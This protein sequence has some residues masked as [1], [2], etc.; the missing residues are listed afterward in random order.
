MT[1]QVIN[2][3]W[4][5]GCQFVMSCKR[6]DAN[7]PESHPGA[8]LRHYYPVT[9]GESCGEYEAMDTPRRIWGIGREPN[10]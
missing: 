8:W 5:T 2:V 9:V 3:C 4:G 6:S 7:Q 10:D 1:M